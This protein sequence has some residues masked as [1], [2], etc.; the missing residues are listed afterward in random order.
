MRS[1]VSNQVTSELTICLPEA[2]KQCRSRG[3][4]DVPH[5]TVEVGGTIQIWRVSII[6]IDTLHIWIIPPT[7]T[8][9]SI[10]LILV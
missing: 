10:S 2:N 6:G 9:I 5:H 3:R 4:L 1:P 8:G 7:S